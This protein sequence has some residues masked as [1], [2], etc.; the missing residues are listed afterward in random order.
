MCTLQGIGITLVCVYI[1]ICDFK[2]GI[3]ADCTLCRETKETVV[4]TCNFSQFSLI[5][6]KYFTAICLFWHLLLVSQN[7]NKLISYQKEEK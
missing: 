3:V 1:N 6:Q 4:F 2:A 5:I 7:L